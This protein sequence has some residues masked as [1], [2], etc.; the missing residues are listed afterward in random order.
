MYM[1]VKY[2]HV[3]IFYV[4]N[5]KSLHVLRKNISTK[6]RQ[7]PDVNRKSLHIW[8]NDLDP[9]SRQHLDKVTQEIREYL[10]S[11][12]NHQGI[13]LINDM[14][15]INASGT[16]RSNSDMVYFTR[17]FDAPFTLVPCRVIR[18][19][20]AINGTPDTTTVFNNEAVTLQTGMAAIFDYDRSAHHIRLNHM[21]A[22]RKDD[23]PRITA[24]LQYIIPNERTAWCQNLHHAWSV[25][26]RDNLVKNQ[27]NVDLSTRIG[28]VG[29]YL[30]TY[31]HYIVLAAL[32]LWI[33]LLFIPGQRV[34][35]ILLIL[36]CAFIIVYY[37]FVLYLLYILSRR[38]G[39]GN[40]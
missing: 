8:Y 6:L 7:D 34:V 36:I 21:Q 33:S 26:S 4:T 28:I 32:I 25:Y 31:M 18:V 1:N 37:C 14:T 20:F 17:H 27:N 12:H 11:R 23:M 24:K 38:R 16:Q 9:E 15:E 29:T 10:V 13:R 2:N 5:V 35:L 40:F 22:R 3:D 19:L 30:A 39:E